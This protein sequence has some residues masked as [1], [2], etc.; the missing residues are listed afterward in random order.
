MAEIQFGNESLCDLGTEVEASVRSAFG[1]CKRELEPLLNQFVQKTKEPNE[2]PLARAI[3]TDEN[4]Q[5]TKLEI[6]QLADGFEAFNR[7]LLD[8]IAH[9]TAAYTLHDICFSLP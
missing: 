2:V 9:G 8:G 4:V 1:R 3:C 5:R 6:L 7:Q